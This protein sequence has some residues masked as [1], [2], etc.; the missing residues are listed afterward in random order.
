ME[1]LKSIHRHILRMMNYLYLEGS[2]F[3]PYT[4]H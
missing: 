2:G 1:H 4:L 3:Y